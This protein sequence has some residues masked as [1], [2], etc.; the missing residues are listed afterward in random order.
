MAQ[1]V[2][3]LFPEVK[4]AI[5]PAI[6]QG[7][8]YDFDRDEPFTEEDLVRIEERMR[9]LSSQELNYSRKE[10]TK[11]EAIG[12][13]KKQQEIYKVEILSEI[14][15]GDIISTYT[16]G[17]FI[18]LC[19]GPHL[20]H[21]GKIKAFKLLKT[22]GAYWRGDERNKMLKRVY[23]ISFPSNKELNEYL[24]ML[25]EAKK[26][27]H[28]KLGKDLDLYSMD[29]EVGAGL[30]LWH[31][32]GA[33]IRYLIE[34][35]WTEAHLKAGYKLIISPH[36][37][38]SNLWKT[39]GHL[40][41]YHENMY[42]PMDIEGQEYY[43]KP[44]NCP[45]HISIY[46][47]SL[48]SYRELP[49]RLAEM[50]TVYRYERSGVLHG[51]MRVRG[52]TQDDA[53]IICTPQQLKEEV[54]KLLGFSI[55]LLRHFGFENFQLYLAT[56]P[57][58][59]IGDVLDWDKATE[60][61]R[62]AL[63]ELALDYILD[64][65][66]GAFYGPKIDIKIKDALNRAWQCTTIQFDFNLPSR[67]NMEYISPVNQPQRPFVIH[68]AVLGS[69]ERFFGTLLEYHAGN[70]PLWL[71]PIQLMIIPIT[72]SQLA[73]AQE[74]KTGFETA[75]FRCE[76]DSRNEKIGYKIRDAEMKKIP[77]MCIIGKKEEDSAQ[78]SLRRH[79]V[80]DLGAMSLDTAKEK[81]SSEL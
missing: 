56:R 12:L 59:A 66:G 18:D 53:H 46:K 70:L 62:Y 19:R 24:Q 22:S 58:D 64:E 23:G 77:Y 13:F 75:G 28:R 27:D 72:E 38:R 31:P 43:L 30:V 63:D 50:G 35:Y 11:E 25:E 17:D 32:N 76:I 79:T 51:L 9:E 5:G 6:E 29:D 3:Q 69:V 80:G 71:C 33:F 14:P 74:I 61:L 49:M 55:D 2:K 34:Q 54:V 52:F 21:T 68:R 60:S 42:S 10:L 4:I 7:F 81:L 41:F 26:R 36:I 73:Y 67:F 37:G 44:M 48:R 16:Q 78:V 45:F 15:D 40:D 47:S 39:S 8:Y 57:E 65:G 20:I 1:A